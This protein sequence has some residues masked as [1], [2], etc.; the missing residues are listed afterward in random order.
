MHFSKK[1]L[2]DLM[3]L[4]TLYGSGQWDF[5]IPQ[6]WLNCFIEVIGLDYQ[7]VRSTTFWVYDP[8]NSCFDRPISGCKEVQ[9]G[10]RF[11]FEGSGLEM[12]KYYL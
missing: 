4:D 10:L 11:F 7:L 12:A 6:S 8:E 9:E 3:E 1:D 2:S 5:A